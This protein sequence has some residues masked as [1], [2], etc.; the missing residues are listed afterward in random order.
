MDRLSNCCVLALALLGCD[1]PDVRFPQFVQDN[2]V[3]ATIVSEI[4]ARLE[5]SLAGQVTGE[6]SFTT[7][8]AGGG[9]MQVARTLGADGAA[10]LA[11]A[12]DDCATDGVDPDGSSACSLKIAGPMAYTY[13]EDDAT[14]FPMV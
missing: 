9:C 8:C 4:D 11:L 7:T 2:V 10:E 1:R 3:V 5:E 12:L 6:T 13:I 14:G